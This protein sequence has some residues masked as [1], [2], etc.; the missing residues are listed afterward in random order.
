MKNLAIAYDGLRDDRAFETF[1]KAHEI[2]PE[3]AEVKNKINEYERI[4]KLSEKVAKDK[5]E[6]KSG[7]KNKDKNKD[8]DKNKNNKE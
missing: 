5:Q 6:Q 1:T 7:N 3:D 4:K 2:N 8:K